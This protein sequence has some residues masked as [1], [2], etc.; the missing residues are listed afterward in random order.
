MSE[1]L[2]YMRGLRSIL[3]MVLLSTGIMSVDLSAQTDAIAKPDSPEKQFELAQ[4][5]ETGAGVERN[6][7]TAIHWYEQAASHGHSQSMLQLGMI[8]YN[9]DILGG[10]LKAD[11]QLSW[12]WFT[13]A[14]AHGQPQ[15]SQDADRIAEELHPLNLRDLKLRAAEVLVY[16]DEAPS[17]V[18]KGIELYSSVAEGGSAKAAEI[19]GALYME[20]T[21]VQRNA[22][23][24]KTWYEKAAEAGSFRAMYELARMAETESPPN[25]AKAFEMYRKA[26]LK[27]HARSMFRVGEIYS[28]GLGVPRDL[29]LAHAWFTVAGYFEVAEGKAAA[30]E[31]DAKLTQRQIERA[32]IEAHNLIVSVDPSVRVRPE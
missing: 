22:V 16:G 15:A 18:E 8:Y 10:T 31:L 27:G 24:A 13:F 19:L 9:G 26:G 30:R 14:A 32:Q 3:T 6:L 29:V 5:Y 20:G 28:G 2:D 1:G 11:N 4:R 25:Q 7:E 23:L 12:L 17:N 21:L